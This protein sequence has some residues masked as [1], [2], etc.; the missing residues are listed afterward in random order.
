[1]R[2]SEGGRYRGKREGRAPPLQREKQEG[3]LKP[4][5]QRQEGA[6]STFPLQ[7]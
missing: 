3:G 6:A 4:P 1:M 2:T 5:L 7:R